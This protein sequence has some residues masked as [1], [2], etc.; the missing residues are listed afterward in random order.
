MVSVQDHMINEEACIDGHASKFK[1]HL[2]L[3]RF[4][5][6]SKETK[7]QV[8]WS[9]LAF[10]WHGKDKSAMNMVKGQEER[11]GQRKE[12]KTHNSR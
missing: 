3:M 10:L 9:H 11:K 6:Y 2:S 5:Q 1:M 8:V 4:P 7:S 12:E